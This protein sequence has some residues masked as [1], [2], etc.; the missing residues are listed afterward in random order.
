MYGRNPPNVIMNKLIITAIIMSGKN[1]NISSNDSPR[2]LK[3]D[4]VLLL[5]SCVAYSVLVF[6]KR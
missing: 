2:K 4:E 6:V 5:Y 1:G 3:F